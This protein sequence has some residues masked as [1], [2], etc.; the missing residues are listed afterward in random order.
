MVVSWTLYA[1]RRGTFRCQIEHCHPFRKPTENYEQRR[2][3]RQDL[4]NTWLNSVA[5]DLDLLTDWWFF[6]R[7]YNL[8]GIALDGTMESQATLALLVFSGIGSVS[9]LLELYQVVFMSPVTF[10]WLP[11]F[12]ILGEDI[13]QILLSLVLSGSFVDPTPI[14]AFNI[15][16]SVY[17]ALIKISG[18]LFLNHCYCCKFTPHEEANSYNN[19]EAG[20]SGSSA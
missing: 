18:E 16:T 20:R 17:S 5:D 14:A 8:Y 11:L 7:M 9:Y 3:Y 6:L 4:W 19:M 15:A 2:K 12:T 1:L 13:P 10:Q